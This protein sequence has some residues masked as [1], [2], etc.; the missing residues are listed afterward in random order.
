MLPGK[1][2]RKLVNWTGLTNSYLIEQYFDGQFS[3]HQR[4]VILSALALGGREAA[5]LPNPKP[6][7]APRIDFPTKALPP[8]LHQ[9][10][11]SATDVPAA[12]TSSMLEAASHDLRQLMISKG[13]KGADSVPEF[14]RERRLRVSKSTRNVSEVQDEDDEVMRRLHEPVHQP[15]VPFK[16]VAAEFFLLPLINRFWQH[17][18]DASTREARGLAAGSRYRGAGTG[19]VLSPMALE[20]FLTTLGLL[21]HAGRHSSVYLSVLCPEALD[22]AATIGTRHL[23]R[24]DDNPAGP[25][26]VEDSEGSKLEAGVVGA[27]LELALITL[28]S[29]Q[30]LD[31]GRSLA[32]DKGT[33]I[34]GVGEW[35]STVFAIE[36]RG[37]EVAAGAGGMREGRVRK[38]AAGVVIRVSDMMENWRGRMGVGM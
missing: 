8:A 27:A 21:M 9:N 33:V 15:V 17:F 11:L 38:A 20:K 23:T 6:Q 29:A 24:P 30:E 14:V 3:L 28:D 5:G 16:D 18:Q 36:E 4:S 26:A 37:G 34:M 2:L 22:L 12:S 32:M 1:L 31:G 13:A 10:Y 19:M 35:A 25:G 7:K